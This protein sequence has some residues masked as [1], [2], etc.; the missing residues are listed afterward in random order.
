MLD[1]QYKITRGSFSSHH[2]FIHHETARATSTTPADWGFT[3]P[4]LGT[5]ETRFLL[6]PIGYT[7]AQIVHAYGYDKVSFD[8][9][10]IAVPGDGR[11]ETVALFEVGVT[12]GLSQDLAVFDRT[13]NL[14]DL[15]SWTSGNARPATPFL[16]TIGFDGGDSAP[17]DPG[18]QGE[19][20]LDVEWLHAVAPA[21][22]IL[23]VEAA[24]A[25][26]LPE[27]DAFAAS[28]PGVVVVSNSYSSDDYL[29]SRDEVDDNHFFT[30]PA[31]HPGVT[32]LD[33]SG[34]TGA[35]SHPP[36][37][38]PNV[39]SVGGTSLTLNAAGNYGSETGW[40][41]SGGGLSFYD[42]LP[43]YQL[44]AVPAGI[45]RRAVPDCGDS[46]Q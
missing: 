2:V 6:A 19:A 23:V 31:G 33:S 22:N 5:L 3:D 37:F 35:P 18:D 9:G 1:I 32:F 17:A 45:R 4:W 15:T 44:G 25:S 12:P 28:Q 27:A 42:S 39:L 14:P 38:S 36:D 21:A 13:F 20:L 26:E 29:E 40:A 16:R 24:D 7:P 46:G 30:T 11:G 34:D 8:V 10:G 43:A 41:G